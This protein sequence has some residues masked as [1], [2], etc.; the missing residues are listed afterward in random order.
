M[1]MPLHTTPTDAP[2]KV[3]IDNPMSAGALKLLGVGAG[4]WYF[5]IGESIMKG[6]GVI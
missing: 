2:A 1:L 4:L 3:A 5:V 6:F